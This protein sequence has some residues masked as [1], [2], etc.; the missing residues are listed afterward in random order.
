MQ[1]LS[2]HK[3]IIHAMANFGV[4]QVLSKIIGFLLIP[5]YTLYLSPEDYGIA[6]LCASIGVFTVVLMRLG[7]T[8]SV[9]RFYYDYFDNETLLRDYVTTIHRMLTFF[10]IAI[11]SIM[12]VFLFFFQEKL[13]P[14]VLFFPF[15]FLV[16][17]NSGFSANS[18]LQKRLLQ[19]QE[20]SKYM[21]KINLAN[22]IIAIVSAIIFIVYFKLGALGF[23]LAQSITTL[24]FFIQAQYYLHSY[25][26]GRFRMKYL[27][28]SIHYGLGLLPHH[29][30]AAAAPLLSKGVL[31]YSGSTAALGIYSLALR[32]TQPLDILYDIFNK[33]FVP[34]YFSLRKKQQELEL[35]N[36]H[37]ITWCL[38]IVI[39]SLSVLIT[40]MLVPLVTPSRF[41]AAV[42]LIPI[43]S[44]SF[45][46][47]VLYMFFL[48]ENYYDKNTKSV[49][50]VTGVGLLVTLL[51]T[52][53]TVDVLKELG[54]AIAF[55]MGF[56]ARAVMGYLMS[57]KYF[58]NHLT[59]TQIIFGTVLAIAVLIIGM[60]LGE[61]DYISRVL[62]AL[63]VCMLCLVY[64]LKLNV[65][66]LKKR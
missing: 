32:F 24:V 64:V 35:K 44:I 54:V 56:V 9:S 31:N 60:W 33:A 23:I 26:K 21:A 14:G 15:I 3:R 13:I 10:S 48:N 51:V 58:L 37:I 39:F 20:K 11:G 25:V 19:C 16:I 12:G 47:Q 45:I 65:I 36:I 62:I 17:I 40:P 46:T 66:K 49:S 38:T 50:A 34:V 59:Y 4:A 8:G 6:E 55:S 22:T 61:H 43:L 53:L 7:V 30:F 41:H 63:L 42:P 57:K 18:D 1:D 52:F 29:L 2:V 5:I 27:S 28:A